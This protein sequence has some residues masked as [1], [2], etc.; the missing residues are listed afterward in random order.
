MEV[1]EIPYNKDLRTQIGYLERIAEHSKIIG[2]ILEL[3]PKLQMP[4]WYLGAGCIAQTVWNLQHGFDL[5]HGIRDYDLVYYDSSDTSYEKEDFYVK[6]IKALLKDFPGRVEVKNEA[7]VHLWYEKHFGYAI[8]PYE[9]VEDAINTWPTTA[10]SVAVKYNDKGEF[11]VYAPYGLND[12][13][14]MIA[15]PNKAQI[16][17][18]IYLSKVGRW[19]K[20]W[21]RLR[22]IPWE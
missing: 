14:G 16:T 19:A 15:R 9:S 7:R 17:K 6:K 8:E 18:E 13:F 10:T 3:A 2:D 21:H 20:I 4:D 11:I 12:L 5:A 1:R 22:V